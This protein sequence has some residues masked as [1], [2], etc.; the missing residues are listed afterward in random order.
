MCLL[1]GKFS[2]ALAQSIGTITYTERD[3]WVNYFDIDPTTTAYCTQFQR[4]QPYAGEQYEVTTSLQN[5]TV[6]EQVARVM[7]AL[8]DP[9][10]QPIPTSVR[11]DFHKGL[12]MAVWYYTDGRS[13]STTYGSYAYNV[14]QDIVN[15]VNSGTYAV[16]DIIWLS[17]TSSDHQQMVLSI[18]CDIDFSLSSTDPDCNANNGSITVSA[19]GGDG[20]YEYSIDGGGWQSS[21]TFS[22]LS[23]GYHYITVRNAGGSCETD[24]KGRTL[25]EQSCCDINASLDTNS[26]TCSQPTSGSVTVNSTGGTGSYEYTLADGNWQTSNIFLGLS[27]GSYAVYV[28]NTDG[29]CIS[30]PYTFTLTGFSID[31]AGL[32]NIQ[33]YDNTTLYSSSDDQIT[34]DLNPTGNGLSGGYT[35][36]ASTGSVSPSTGTYGTTTSF[37]LP[38]GSAGGGDVTLTITDATDPACNLQVIVFDPGSCAICPYAC[39]IEVADPPSV[40]SSV[41]AP[42]T[43]SNDISCGDATWSGESNLADADDLYATSLAMPQRTTSAC[44]YLNGFGFSIPECSTIDGI[45]VN[46]EGH[47][48]GNKQVSDLTVHLLDAAGAITGDDQVPDAGY[49]WS[50][51]VDALW[52][53]GG[54]TDM[55]GATLTEADVNSANFGFMLQ[56]ETAGGSPDTGTAY[57]DQVTMTVYYTPVYTVEG[58]GTFSVAAVAEATAYNWSV[59][60]GA[61]V[62]SG[63]GSREASVD[64]TNTPEGCYD[65]CVETVGPEECLEGPCC[66]QVLVVPP[67]CE[68]IDC[69]PVIITVE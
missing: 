60:T 69:L 43:S 13:C 17:P 59:P 19:T 40:S 35:V 5:A 61:T 15:K 62:T 38:S 53:Y 10:Y 64:F 31:N 63:A 28:R 6:Q 26:P 55:W 65:V 36:S 34:F 16:Q 12:G 67:A 11:N 50:Q 9:A 27:G 41:A 47:Y 44:L 23:P 29:S 58:S 48:E 2:Q 42:T 1:H 22:N 24:P 37:S 39:P 49:N 25:V 3:F 18:N 8:E 30:G 4:S 51:T 54:S 21:S 7:S 57:L 33:C 46:L 32:T 68:S 20:N 52:S 56:V 66:R 45:E 14:C